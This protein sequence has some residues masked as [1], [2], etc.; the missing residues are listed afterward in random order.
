MEGGLQLQRL[1][2]EGVGVG[3][4]VVREG[5]QVPLAE[6]GKEFTGFGGGDDGIV[7]AADQGLNTQ[8]MNTSSPAESEK[9]PVV[10]VFSVTSSKEESRDVERVRSN[11]I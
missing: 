1:A 8:T 7:L 11:S 10:R 9:G 2:F 3:G 4:W 6:E 5:E